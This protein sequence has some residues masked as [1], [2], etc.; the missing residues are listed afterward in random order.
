MPRGVY[1]RSKV[2]DKPVEN[3]VPKKRGRPPGKKTEAKESL[4]NFVKEVAK[5]AKTVKAKK[6]K[7][8]EEILTDVST[9]NSSYKSDPEVG[10][11]KSAVYNTNPI[12]LSS[13]VREN[14]QTLNSLYAVFGSQMPSL[15]T[16]ISK[17]VET[18]SRLSNEVFGIPTE[19]TESPPVVNS[20]HKT[21]PLPVS[22]VPSLPVSH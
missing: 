11:V 21:I 15:A 20:E 1:D 22:T 6:I 5:P 3:A 2:N 13:Q 17:Q 7:K 18:L 9:L 4:P 14:L 12:Y 8:S 16:E 10:M 19:L